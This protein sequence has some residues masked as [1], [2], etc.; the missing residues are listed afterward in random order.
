MKKIK[1]SL[2]PL[3]IASFMML[4]LSC[5]ENNG[6]NEPVS[7]DKTRPGIITNVKVDNFNGGAYI[8]YDLPN[9]DNLL[10]V[11][12]RYRINDKTVRETKASYYKDTIVVEGFAKSKEY[13]VTLYTVSRANV[14]SDPIEI[15]VRP[16]TPVYEYVQPSFKMGEDFGGINIQGLN[17]LKKEIGLILLAKNK[18]TGEME[19]QDQFFTKD[20]KVNYAVRGFVNE[21]RDF[22]LYVTDKWGN[23]SDTLT[24]TL[25]PLYEELV[26]KSKLSVYN[27]T[28][29]SPIGFGWVLPNLWNGNTGGD[30]WHTASGGHP[31]FVASFGISKTYKLSRF[32][33]WERAGEYTYGLGN[34]KDF[35]LWGSNKDRPGEAQLPL[36]APEGT[37]LGDWINLGNYHFPDPP[38]GN[39]PGSTN[40]ADE[41]FVKA[42]VSFNVPFNAPSVKFLRIAVR[43]TW[44]NSDSAH[45]IELSV[46]GRPE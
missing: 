3:F 32:V 16:L 24:N 18:I 23:I 6:F 9:S 8:T 25:T 5:K 30:G 20:A 35:S 36:L 34:P 26:D 29:D 44:G 19:V 21:P 11:L 28:T 43:T 31:P 7:A 40:S 17:P 2:L 46:Y 33:I 1:K 13:D 10:Y 45:I 12:A 4:V 41:T 14:M 27:L 39:P 37:Q 38:S 15:K 22:G 42:G